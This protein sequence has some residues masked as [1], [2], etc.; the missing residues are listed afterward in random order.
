MSNP[1]DLENKPI[2]P[3]DEEYRPGAQNPFDDA[4][5]PVSATAP[6][7]DPPLFSFTEDDPNKLS[8]F[9]SAISSGIQGFGD[10]IGD[11]LKAPAIADAAGGFIERPEDGILYKAGEAVSE[12]FRT[13][14]KNPEHAGGLP[15]Q[16]GSGVGSMAGFLAGG[17]AGGTAKRAL[18]MA[19][20]LGAGSQATN[21]YADALNS[22]ASIE[23]AYNA[24]GL[25][26]LVGSSEAVPIVKLLDRFDKGTGGSVRRV[27]INGLKGGT[28]E[29][30][31]EAFQSISSNLIASKL[32]E[33]DPDREVFSG[34]GTASGIG[35]GAG[36]LFNTVASLIGFRARGTA[37]QAS[38]TQEPPT[39]APEQDTGIPEQVPAAAMANPFDSP[40][41]QVPV[42]DM[43][44]TPSVETVQTPSEASAQEA[45]PVPLTEPISAQS[46]P[47]I[48]QAEMPETVNQ[49]DFVTEPGENHVGFRRDAPGSGQQALEDPIRR[50][51]ILKKF[52]EGMGVPIYTG[53]ISPQSKALGF[54]R[55]GIEE[56]RLS[57]ANDI[58]VAAHEMA[59]LLD[60]RVPEISQQ[61]S[62]KNKVHQKELRDLSYDRKIVFEGFAEYVRLWAT[63]PEK[64]AQLAPNFN[65]WFEDFLSSSEYG[66]V[67]RQARQDMTA[68]FEQDALLRA[69]SKIGQTEEPKLT[70]FGSRLRQAVLDDLQ[71]VKVM[72]REITGSNA[73]AGLYETARLS[74]SKHSFIEGALIIGAP[75]VNKDGSH[76]FEGKGLKQVL[77]PVSQEQDEFWTYAAGRSAAELMKQGREN[78]FT[79]NEIKAMLA[80]EKPEFKTAFTEYQKWNTKILDFAQAKGIINPETRKLWKRA[81]YLPFYR[82]GGSSPSGSRGVQGNWK[83]I[84]ALTGGTEN[85]QEIPKNVIQN[86][87]TLIDAAITNEVR[88][89]AAKLSAGKGGAHFM[90]RIPKDQ[91]PVHIDREQIEAALVKA[92][93]AKKREQLPLDT[94][95]LIDDMSSGLGPLTTFL[96]RNQ[97]PQGGNIVAALDQG[98]PVFYEVADPLLLRSLTNLNRPGKNIVT[99]LIGSVRRVGQASITLTPDFAMANIVRD[100]IMGSIMS[101]S[102]FVPVLDSIKGIKSR[103]MQDETYREFIA[104]GGGFASHLA[105]EEAF[106]RHVEKLYKKKGIN[107]KSVL[108]SPKKLL[109]FIERLADSFEMSTRLGEF[110]RAIK[111]GQHPR[112]A[113]FRGREVSTDFAMRG[114]GLPRGH[115]EHNNF[116]DIAAVVGFMYDTVI[117]LKAAANGMDRTYRGFVED[118]NKGAIAAKA[119]L[120][121]V[122]SMALY[123]I[124]KDNPIYQDLEDWDKDTHWHFFIPNL[125]SDENT[126][127][128]DLFLHFRLP[129]IWEIGAIS[130]AAE[131]TV[132]GIM[133]GEPVET[134][135]NI[136]RVT[137]ATFGLEYIPQLFAP[138]YEVY[139]NRNRFTGRPVEGMALQG[140]QP[141]ARSSAYTY[142]SLRK[143]G[144]AVRNVPVLNKISP[145]QAQH[146]LRG[147][148]NTWATY[149]L[150]TID[151][152]FFDDVPDLRVDQYP[153]IK[154]FWRQQP[155]RSS[156]AV[157]DFYDYLKEATETRRT[158]RA[159]IRSNREVLAKELEY[160]NANRLY[161]PLMKANKTMRAFS[162]ESKKVYNAK[163]L[164]ETQQLAIQQSGIT[165]KK[166]KIKA[167]SEG[168]W[169]DNGALKAFLLDNILAARNEFAKKVMKKVKESEK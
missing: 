84:Q 76:S 164:E 3:F 67:M 20:T 68:W 81:A 64:A 133:D 98:K 149:G 135:E 29:A 102:G 71:G 100:T 42:P 124:N 89:E 120:L 159:L 151:A 111:Q 38:P 51:G 44:V 119:G 168:V 121:G 150:S 25:G 160:T 15:D 79:K 34:V 113:A 6:P 139:A 53:R 49:T 33:Y 162:N 90:A 144:E 55:R 158:L 19:G 21:Q 63:Q 9:Q 109:N 86:A 161:K 153:V 138:A 80:L 125:N 48:P 87:A 62:G 166:L 145:T 91:I 18:V 126:P 137:L 114:G 26:A 5:R 16:I 66:P 43:A 163:G 117:F 146:L 107:P 103:M 14:P 85:L 22:G 83:G 108:N 169:E 104:N 99:R 136:A 8:S 132:E 167:M 75:V 28:E 94:Q 92:L 142:K 17:L 41:Q 106:S 73:P 154:R 143:A 59:H 23:D 141:W 2:N 95:S 58:E 134:A 36:A 77:E 88:L 65:G 105:D 78:L 123:L 122:M 10:V 30:V 7:E 101:R 40:E 131:R 157:G 140:L 13:A 24:A 110:D 129:K 1:F 93:G 50:D 165:G 128:E 118:P 156:K 60:D 39:A 127:P 70:N 45:P 82:V 97:A 4:S 35:F 130:S 11:A 56:V 112:H 57:N 47:D 116:D 148:F 46:V 72:E 152:V 155:S 12:F 74:R 54:Y 115:P 69:R 32:I 147:Y 31:Q 96:L 37:S 61:W 27:I 52:A